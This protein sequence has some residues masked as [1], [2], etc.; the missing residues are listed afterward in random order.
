MRESL[1][2]PLGVRTKTGPHRGTPMLTF[3]LTIDRTNERLL[4]RMRRSARQRGHVSQM[5][6][7]DAI[8]ALS[9]VGS[10]EAVAAVLGVRAETIVAWRRR[11][12]IYGPKGL[13]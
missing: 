4:E 9:R 5:R 8:L 6:R 7:L 13:V 3:R 1:G 11:F 10:I 2:I 12:V